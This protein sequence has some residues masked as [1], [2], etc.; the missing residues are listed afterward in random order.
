MRSDGEV[1]GELIT[2][3]KEMEGYAYNFYL[4]E[5]CSEEC[6]LEDVKKYK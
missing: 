4:G 1:L 3:V 6:F 2:L 5:W